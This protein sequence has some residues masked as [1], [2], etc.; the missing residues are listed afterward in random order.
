MIS[1]TFK[2]CIFS[3]LLIAILQ[4][5]GTPPPNPN[6]HEN[7]CICLFRLCQLHLCMNLLPKPHPK[8]NKHHLHPYLKLSI[9]IL[10]RMPTLESII[11]KPLNM[12]MK[13]TR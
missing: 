6:P 1:K 13:N 10:N 11:Y 5:Q 2:T 9:K 12:V 8:I 4:A 7:V 3:L